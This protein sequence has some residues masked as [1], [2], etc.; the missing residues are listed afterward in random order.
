MDTLEFLS[1]VNNLAGISGYE[2]NVAS[3]TADI[4]KELCDDVEEIGRAHV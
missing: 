2:K 1:K 4:F 3:I